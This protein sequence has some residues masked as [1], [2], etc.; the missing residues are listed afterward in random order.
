MT[1]LILQRVVDVINHK[2]NMML[3]H[4]IIWPNEYVDAVVWTFTKKLKCAFYEST[5]SNYPIIWNPEWVGRMWWPREPRRLLPC[6]CLRSSRRLP[7]ARHCKIHQ[8]VSSFRETRHFHPSR[9]FSHWVNRNTVF[10]PVRLLCKAL[11][12]EI[13]LTIFGRPLICT[14]AEISS[15][16]LR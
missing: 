10:I 11:R 6:W 5:L 13:N 2:T 12:E 9:Q 8:R 15:G 1:H 16:L 7:P 14:L 4:I 3:N